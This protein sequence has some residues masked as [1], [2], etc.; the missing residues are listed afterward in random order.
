MKCTLVTILCSGALLVGLYGSRALAQDPFH[1][2][3]G[4]NGGPFAGS[5][6]D[7]PAQIIVHLSSA[8]IQSVRLR[9]VETDL[10]VRLGL[11]ADGDLSTGPI[12]TGQY[13][14]TVI[15]SN[16]TQR[17]YTVYAD[18]GR[19]ALNVSGDAGQPSTDATVSA[20][21]LTIPADVRRRRDSAKKALEKGDQQRADKEL[22]TA[23]EKSPGCAEALMLRGVLRMTQAKFTD[24]QNDAEQAVKADP[25]FAPAYFLL[26]S[27]LQ[28]TGNF[29]AAQRALD[30][31]LRMAPDA[32]QG[33]FELARLLFTQGKMMAA[34]KQLEAASPSAPRSFT[35][36]TL[37]RGLTLLKLNRL[38]DAAHSLRAFLAAAPSAPEAAQVSKLLERIGAAQASAPAAPGAH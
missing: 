35:G 36:L 29:D 26:G 19:T 18:G 12:R 7:F 21:S 33:H 20:K 13:T 1:I 37:L 38:P 9:S 8:G 11:T 34:L 6:R 23:L 28:R 15:S 2:Q 14:L 22:S 31:G 25:T 30:N 16:G 3:P 17:D 24:A 27:V 4:E 10:D 32:W 5:A